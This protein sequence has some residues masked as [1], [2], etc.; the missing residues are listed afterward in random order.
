MTS[1]DVAGLKGREREAR[2]MIV[3]SEETQLAGRKSKKKLCVCGVLCLKFC[4]SGEY[5]KDGGRV[6][7]VLITATGEP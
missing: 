4:Q 2:L 1:R 5:F 3:S 6:I 7:G